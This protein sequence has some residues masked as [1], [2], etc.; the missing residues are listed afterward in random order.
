MRNRKPLALGLLL[1]LALATAA[2]AALPQQL[3]KTA[4]WRSSLVTDDQ[5]PLYDADFVTMVKAL[6]AGLGGRTL[7]FLGTFTECFG[8]GFADEL[9]DP[10]QAFSRYGA[11]SAS[12]YFEPATYNPGNGSFYG[13]AWNNRADV[14]GPPSDETITTTAWDA[15]DITNLVVVPGVPKNP[16][17]RVERTQYRTDRLGAGKP[18]EPLHAAQ[19]NYVILW[20]GQPEADDYKDVDDLF[21]I[22][23][24]PRYGYVA[25]EIYILWGN[26]A[27]PNAADAWVP[28]RSATTANLQWALNSIQGRI[29]RQPMGDSTQLFFWAGDHGNVDAPITIEVANSSVGLPGTGVA[30]QVGAG[31]VGATIYKAGAGNN[32]ARLVENTAG[33]PGGELKALSFGDDFQNAFQLFNYSNASAS[34]VVYFS[35]D[36][37]SAGLPGTDVA[38]ERTLVPAHLPGADIYALAGNNG[39]RQVFDG[40]RNLGL[41]KA[42]PP[43]DE[44][45]DFVLRDIDRMLSLQTG[46]PTRPIFFT[47]HKNGTIWVY[48]P[49]FGFSYPYFTWPGPDFANPPRIVDALAMVVSLNRRDPATNKL[50]FNKA[51]DSILFSI[52]RGEIAAPW[53]GYLPCQIL[54]YGSGK[55]LFVW[56]GCKDLGLLNTDNV[57]GLDIGA[58]QYGQ[59]ITFDQELPWPQYSYPNGSPGSQPPPGPS[60]QP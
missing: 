25:N 2:G 12:T 60:P 33:T 21:T 9:S 48:D 42:N 10:A 18:P 51:Q 47:N 31:L 37:P 28:D 29:N 3:R 20:I 34:A 5:K 39:N 14:A 1:S 45:N 32:F 43:N 50:I 41:A 19:H 16:R 15:I 46:L 59:P 38:L 23:T 58:G 40:T 6:R 49:A 54:G 27:D 13:T 11:N 53:I 17:S 57:D 30:G 26:G 8:G 36:N 22:L 7:N 44:L 35:V 55:N 24:G 52:G 4:G 56:A